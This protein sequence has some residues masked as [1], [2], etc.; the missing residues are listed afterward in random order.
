MTETSHRY[1]HYTIIFYS[2]LLDMAANNQAA[3]ESSACVDCLVSLPGTFEE[4]QVV[5]IRS[6]TCGSLL[7]G[8]RIVVAVVIIM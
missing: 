1:E 3:Q 7:W 6:W 5:K 2:A 4:G 8:G